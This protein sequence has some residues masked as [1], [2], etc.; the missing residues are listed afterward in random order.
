MK[1]CVFHIHFEEYP[2]PMETY[3]NKGQNPLKQLQFLHMLLLSHSPLP[4][5]AVFCLP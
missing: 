2:S 3:F 5:P 1:L 4:D